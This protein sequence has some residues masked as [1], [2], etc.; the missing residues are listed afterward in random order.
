MLAYTQ[1][2]AHTRPMTEADRRFVCNDLTPI[3]PRAGD[4]LG[5]WWIAALEAERGVPWHGLDGSPQRFYY[6]CRHFDEETRACLN[7]DGRPPICRAFPGELRANSALP[8]P[9][10][11]RR[12]LGETPQPVELFLAETRRRARP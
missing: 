5:A 3:G 12:D 9:C 1:A 10:E 11:Y 2:E 8:P 6:R 7:Y 4:E